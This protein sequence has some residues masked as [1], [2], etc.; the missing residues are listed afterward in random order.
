MRVKLIEYIW[1]EFNTNHKMKIKYNRVSSASQSGDRFK[2][3]RSEYDLTLFDKCSGRLIFEKR[4]QGSKLMQMIKRGEVTK[5]VIQDVSRLGRNL[6]DVAGTLQTFEDHNV[7]LNVRGLG[8]ESLIDGK[9]NP[10]FKL[11]IAVLAAVA[12]MELETKK[13]LCKSGTDAARARGVVFGRPIAKSKSVA[14]LLLI[15]KNKKIEHYLKESDFSTREIGRL[16]EVAPST[17]QRL[18]KALGLM[19]EQRSQLGA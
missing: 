19:S 1:Y 5:V 3:D 16:L 11:I 13:E 2:L 17:I 6:A 4:P 7:N 18:K 9:P 14:E 15:P 12:E 10:T 8:M